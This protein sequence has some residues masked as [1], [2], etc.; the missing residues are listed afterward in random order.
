M[1]LIITLF[2]YGYRR[3]CRILPIFI[4]QG[5]PARLEDGSYWSRAVNLPCLRRRSDFLS[6]WESA[7]CGGHHRCTRSRSPGRGPEAST[8]TSSP[9]LY[10]V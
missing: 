3:F 1:E 2:L 10:L 6:L 4:M 9:P 8:T 5:P 7:V